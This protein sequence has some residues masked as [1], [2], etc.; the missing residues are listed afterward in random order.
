MPHALHILLLSEE[1]LRRTGLRETTLSSRLYGESKKI[2]SLRKG[3]DLTLSRYRDSLQW[4]HENW[5]PNA[6]WPDGIARPN[7]KVAA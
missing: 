5:P 1:W 7:T 3:S 6:I 2:A 4:F